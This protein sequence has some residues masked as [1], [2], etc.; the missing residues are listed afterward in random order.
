[1]GPAPEQPGVTGPG[2]NICVGNPATGEFFRITTDGNSNKEP[3]WV[4]A[5]ATAGGVAGP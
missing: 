3:D 2:W 5:K 1:M 4:P